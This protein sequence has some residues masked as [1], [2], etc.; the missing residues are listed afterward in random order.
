M[1]FTFVVDLA[2]RVELGIDPD[3]VFWRKGEK[4]MHTLA[5]RL[6]RAC[7]DYAWCMIIKRTV[8][9]TRGHVPVLLC[10]MSQAVYPWDM[11]A[12]TTRC[13][14]LGL[15][16]IKYTVWNNAILYKS[17]FVQ[18]PSFSFSLLYQLPF[19][20]PFLTSTE[21]TYIAFKTHVIDHS[22]PHTWTIPYYYIQ[23]NNNNTIE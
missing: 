5:F 3:Q 4:G 19:L 7:F 16:E 18:R 12:I 15:I 21:N 17:P 1:Q 14:I 20:P 10:F 8:W 9:C 6:V 23:N 13:L 2:W 22:S 11:F